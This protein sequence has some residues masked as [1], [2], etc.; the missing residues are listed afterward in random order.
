MAYGPV[1][2][3][4]YNYYPHVRRLRNV[5]V[6]TQWLRY[7]RV[8]FL[9]PQRNQRR[10]SGPPASYALC[11]ASSFPRG[12]AGRAQTRPLTSKL[13]LRLKVFL[14]LN[15]PPPAPPYIFLA[16]CLSTRT[17]VP[18]P[19]RPK[20]SPFVDT[21]KVIVYPITLY[22]TTSTVFL[23]VFKFRPFDLMVSVPHS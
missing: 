5:T 23:M 6:Y 20:Y 14:H 3:Q 2:Q 21:I 19:F 7:A 13:L 12:A 10:F 16:R 11:S 17:T 15:P 18:F 9:L 22:F 4:S 8:L 1:E